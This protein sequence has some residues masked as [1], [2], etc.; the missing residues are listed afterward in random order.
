VPFEAEMAVDRQ[1]RHT[2]SGIELFPEEYI[3]AGDRAF[4]SEIHKCINFIWNKEEFPEEW[5]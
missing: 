5:K 2:S 3:K 1:K 4:H